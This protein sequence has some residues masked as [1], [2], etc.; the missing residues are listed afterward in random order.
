V[1]H[2]QADVLVDIIRQST[3]RAA[4]NKCPFHS[5]LYVYRLRTGKFDAQLHN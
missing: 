5:A 2:D 1:L 4:G 3:A